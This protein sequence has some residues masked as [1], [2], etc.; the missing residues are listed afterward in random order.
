MTIERLDTDVRL[1]IEELQRIGDKVAPE[2]REYLFTLV[3]TLQEI[4]SE[5][6][7]VTNLGVALND[8]DAIYYAL[9]DGN[10]VYPKGTWR[11]IQVGDNLEDQVLLGGDSLSGTWT[12]AQRRK[13]PKT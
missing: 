13:R 7:E 1:P 8:G 3:K 4:L 6:A 2:L 9:P 10:A 12:M 5:N 11:R